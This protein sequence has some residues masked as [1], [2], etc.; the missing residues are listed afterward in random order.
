[1][2]VSGAGSA[3]DFRQY[4]KDHRGAIGRW[5]EAGPGVAAGIGA[6][7]VITAVA[8][9]LHLNLTTAAFIHLVI[10]VLVA[11]QSGFW[12]ASVV[13][14]VAA[15]CQLYFLVPPVLTW[16]VSD[17]Q[18]WIALATFE[19][20][21]LIVSRL[22]DEAARRTLDATRRRE[23]TEGLYEVS[24]LAL[25]MDR[26]MDPAMQM[27]AL[28]Q[29]VFHCE[30]AGLFD[31]EAGRFACTG[32]CDAA[33]EAKARAAYIANREDEFEEASRTWLCVLRVGMRPTGALALR[34]GELSEPVAKALA[35]LAAVALERF[36]ALEKESLAEA[37]RQNEQLRTAVLDALA[38]DVK[39]P[40]TAI[41][42]ASSGLLEVGT[43][44]R[45]QNE[46]VQLIDNEAERLDEITNRLL[47]MARLD[48]RQVRIKPQAVR[49]D[50][51]LKQ[52]M[53][54][55]AGR[56]PDH[57]LDAQGMAETLLV[58]GDGNLLGMCISQLIDNAVK[59]SAAGSQIRIRAHQTGR[60]VLVSVNNRGPVIPAAELERIFERFYRAPGTANHVAGTGLGLSITRKIATAHSGRVWATSDDAAGT[61][62]YLVL[63]AAAK[64]K[65]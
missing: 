35:S 43:M 11:R 18:N 59:Y 44:A 9:R 13:S 30:G 1:M 47:G 51:L 27:T 40:L 56:A 42:A 65:A 4:G 17:P 39:T 45:N 37:A 3:V 53:S 33:F 24:R 5:R 19:Y 20:C 50:L 62:F 31:M 46:L 25:V 12:P 60:E 48:E 41:R 55:F 52:A 28:I 21:A 29:R 57:A 23:E 32:A 38:H 22:S 16:V 64:G 36:R 26:S 54:A 8:F 34:G 7:G 6:V 10:V 63:P 14:V 49:M 15:A 2:T 58:A 61:T